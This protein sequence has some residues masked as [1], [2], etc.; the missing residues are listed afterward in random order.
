MKNAKK[1]R[2]LIKAMDSEALYQFID[3]QLYE[4]C[5]FYDDAHIIIQGQDCNIDTLANSIR[6]HPLFK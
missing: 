3:K 6:M 4:R 5:K 2:P 1:I